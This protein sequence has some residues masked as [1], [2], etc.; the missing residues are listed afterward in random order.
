MFF[1]KA[2]DERQVDCSPDVFTPGKRVNDKVTL[3]AKYNLK[4]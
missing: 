3:A 4:V 1:S 2:T